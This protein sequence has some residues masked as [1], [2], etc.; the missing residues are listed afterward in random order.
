MDLEQITEPLTWP[1][2]EGSLMQELCHDWFGE[3]FGPP[4]QYRLV[5]D[6][7]HLWLIA[8]R[9]K[10]A[11]AH[12]MGVCGDFQAELWKHDVAELFI[13]D[14]DFK[15]YLEFNLSPR[16][17]WWTERFSGLRQAWPL[18][19]LPEVLTHASDDGQGAWYA[20]LGLPL[21]WLQETIGWGP[22]SP[23][24]VTFILDSPEQRFLTACDLGDGEP[25][26]HRPQGFSLPNQPID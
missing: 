19:A 5:E 10:P 13:A 26:F 6:P 20:A 16:G 25:D 23:I 2:R 3:S 12:P 8:G 11:N 22:Q 7:H 9:E 17:A 24:N 18:E 4:A 15:N 14:P 1:P 21:G